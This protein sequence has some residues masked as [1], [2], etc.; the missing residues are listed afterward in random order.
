MMAME[1]EWP[2]FASWIAVMRPIWSWELKIVVWL[3]G[4]HTPT[5]PPPTMSTSTWRTGLLRPSV[6]ESQMQPRKKSLQSG[7]REKIDEIQELSYCPL[8]RIERH[9]WVHQASSQSQSVVDATY[10]TEVQDQAKTIAIGFHPSSISFYLILGA[11]FLSDPHSPQ[12]HLAVKAG[13]E[14]Q[15]HLCTE[16]CKSWEPPRNM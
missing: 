7:E 8:R 16:L 6:I 2:N 14:H 9:S 1:P 10:L 3:E 11:P 15:P 12:M 4:K 5:G 13:Y